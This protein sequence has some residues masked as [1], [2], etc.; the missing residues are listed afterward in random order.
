[1]HNEAYSSWFMCL[2]VQ[3]TCTCMC[4]CV[5]VRDTTKKA[6]F[7]KKTIFIVI[8]SLKSYNTICISWYSQTFKAA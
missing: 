8:T 1:M 7:K 5:C 6:T 2:Y 3:D 4:M